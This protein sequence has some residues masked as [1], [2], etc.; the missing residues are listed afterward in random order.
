M[1][2]Y[3]MEISSPVGTLFLASDGEALTQLSFGEKHLFPKECAVLRETARQIGEYFAGM[4]R[5]FDLPVRAEGTPFQTAVWQALTEIPYGRT[6]SYQALA[7]AVGNPN[8]CR[9]VGMANHRNPVAIIIP[10]HRVIGKDSS[11]TGYAGGLEAKRL[12][13][14]LE[15]EYAEGSSVEI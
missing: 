3:N 6:V 13:L 5:S 4:R 9:A 14:A 8:A 15:K 12:L 2:P 7:C 1:Y 11:L 10:C